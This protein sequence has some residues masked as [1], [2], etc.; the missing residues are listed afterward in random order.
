[1][2]LVKFLSYFFYFLQLKELYTLLNENYVEDDDCLFR[3]DY[4]PEFLKWYVHQFNN[5]VL[6]VLLQNFAATFI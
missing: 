6:L 2:V 4:P 3:F 5:Y 1:M